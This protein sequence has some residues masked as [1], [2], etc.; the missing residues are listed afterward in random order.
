MN[1]FK[2]LLPTATVVLSA[3]GFST[4]WCGAV[5]PNGALTYDVT[6]PTNLLWD[7]SQAYYLRSPSLY[8]SENPSDSESGQYTFSF[9]ADFVQDAAGKLKGTGITSIDVSYFSNYVYTSRLSGTYPN[10]T[11][12]VSGSV[13][14]RGGVAKVRFTAIASVQ[15]EI[16]SRPTRLNVKMAMTGYCNG[17]T[18]IGKSRESAAA[19]GVWRGSTTAYFMAGMGF[20]MGDGSWELDLNLSNDGVRKITGTAKVTLNSGASLSFAVKG[21]YNSKTDSS[22]LV[23]IPNPDSKGS[24]LRVTITGDTVTGLQGKMFG[25]FIRFPA[26]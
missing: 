8:L 25:Q 12:K 23:L 24:S 4:F 16:D 21:N 14:S 5:I 3:F 13:S 1:T 2:K 11:Y 15:T 9:S 20:G 10:A 26:R 19:S 18:I 22:K 17:R 6:D 7:L